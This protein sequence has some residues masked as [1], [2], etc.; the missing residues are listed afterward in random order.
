MGDTYF[1]LNSSGHGTLM[2]VLVFLEK[3]A[4]VNAA[5]PVCLFCRTTCLTWHTRASSQHTHGRAYGC[6]WY[7]LRTSTP[8][9]QDHQPRQPLSKMH[10]LQWLLSDGTQAEPASK[11]LVG[12]A[13]LGMP[14]PCL[15]STQHW[16]GAG[17]CGWID[18]DQIMC[19]PGLSC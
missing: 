5:P 11:V 14:C 3:E 15:C 8:Y 19:T 13:A 4:Y 17:V 9:R 6:T 10:Q 18:S 2:T 1:S 12:C 7:I 16:P